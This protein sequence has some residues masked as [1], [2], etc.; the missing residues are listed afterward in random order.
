MALR[1]LQKICS[2]V[3]LLTFVIFQI[4]VSFVLSATTSTSS[5][6]V[7]A[8]V[9]GAEPEEE[10]SPSAPPS[11]PPP[12]NPN[13]PLPS[14]PLQAYNIVVTEVTT[15]SFKLALEY[16][17]NA[18]DSFLIYKVVNGVK[19]TTLQTGSH[20]NP[21][22]NPKFSFKDLSEGALIAYEINASAPA[23]GET[24]KVEGT[25]QLIKTDTTAPAVLNFS[26]VLQS[27]GLARL[28]WDATENSVAQLFVKRSG[29]ANFTQAYTSLLNSS[30]T[31]LVSGIAGSSSDVYIILTDTANNSSQSQLYKVTFG[32]PPAPK[33]TSLLVDSITDTSARITFAVD[34]PV[35]SEISYTVNGISKTMVGPQGTAGSVILTG[36]SANSFV[37]VSVSVVDEYGQKGI[38]TT[39]F[40][41]QKD[42]IKPSALSN[43]RGVATIT[44]VTPQDVT[45]GIGYTWNAPI[46]NDVASVK[47]TYGGISVSN[48]IQNQK[49]LFAS[50]FTDP[51][52]ITKQVVAQAVVV[53]TSGNISDVVNV[54]VTLPQPTIPDTDQ[55]GDGI[56]NEQDNCP[57]ISNPSQKDSD[58]DGL[59]DVCD[60]TPFIPQTDTDKD[61]IPNDQDNCPLI[62]NSD[63]ADF[64]G[65]GIGD[66]CDTSTPP[67]QPP[68]QPPLLPP[69]QPPENPLDPFN[70]DKP[71]SDDEAADGAVPNLPPKTPLDSL[72]DLLGITDS[73][74]ERGLDKDGNKIKVV[75]YDV[76]FSTQS[77][78]ITLAYHN[79]GV[80]LLPYFDLSVILPKSRI[81]QKKQVR[82]V[83][84]VQNE[85]TVICATN[86]QT[87]ACKLAAPL[88][89]TQANIVVSY[90]DGTQDFV[91][92]SVRIATWGQVIGDTLVSGK[93]PLEGAQISLVDAQGKMVN[94]QTYGQSNPL[95]SS[96]KGSYGFMVPNGRYKVIITKEK[97]REERSVAFDITDNVFNEPFTLLELPPGLDLTSASSLA[98]TLRLRSVY[99]SKLGV[100][101]GGKL[102]NNPEYQEAADNT[103]A[104]VVTAVAVANT[105]VA[106][107]TTLFTY[108]Q[109][110][111]TQPL[112][113]FGR[114]KRT[115]WGTVYHSLTKNPVD[116]AYVRLVDATTKRI[117]QTKITDIHG[118]YAFFVQPGNY[119]VQVAKNGFVYPTQ[120]LANQK[121]DGKFL[122][123]YHGEPITVTIA[124]QITPNVP[125]DPVDKPAADV[126]KI[127]LKSRLRALQH[128]L[129]VTGPVLS[130]L[131]FIISRSVISGIAFLAQIILYIGARRIA[132]PPK[133]KNWGIVYDHASK[134]PLGKVVARIFDTEYNKLL[135]T[136]ITDTKG[137]FAFLA[138]ARKYYVTYEK[139]GY[140]KRQSDV[141]DLTAQRDPT[142]IAEKVPLQKI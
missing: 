125:L 123:V 5:V 16:N 82:E 57:T 7:G 25:V 35:N 31:T 133:P 28:T 135:D 97:Y 79:G 126:S 41:T 138:S 46:E 33:V 118:R 121:D 13:V 50:Q 44:K 104:P 87:Y 84:I 88:A 92:Y 39:N 113:L 139:E 90:V 63:Q 32:L 72:G 119:L 80:T 49:Y 26:S 45:W 117:I 36:L 20:P 2:I 47:V 114:R 58:K 30:F 67:Q 111:A 59:G 65:N 129:V 61:G 94:M 132:F 42:S 83:S 4:K 134:S 70:P 56:P 54:T 81:P 18:N 116:L 106:T 14:D 43:F 24:Y 22:H 91:P 21:S 122:D 15:S 17:K 64:D 103:V 115:F 10:G 102:L 112:L 3:F 29:E 131:A 93:I 68:L 120:L 100:V 127:I 128:M 55:D 98:E 27:S 6:T 124:S 137:R 110:L 52:K 74:E 140:A 8:T 78:S 89:T 48:A 40:I 62:I 85:N 108:L 109:F 130:L 95:V 37:A 101:E 105:A 12:S 1:V 71:V 51:S 76:I 141:F 60:P 142:L 11:T 66:V 75:V 107:G 9:P 19:T 69:Q 77:N 86:T 96:A 23:L 136:Q 34:A 38:R 99:L 53:D 73:N